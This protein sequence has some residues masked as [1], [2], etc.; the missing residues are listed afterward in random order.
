MELTTSTRAVDS[1]LTR[2]LGVRLHRCIVD[3]VTCQLLHCTDIFMH[4]ADMMGCRDKTPANVTTRK[5]TNGQWLH[6]WIISDRTPTHAPWTGNFTSPADLTAR[7]AWILQNTTRRRLIDG[8][9]CLR[10]WVVDQEYH[11]WSIKDSFTLSVGMIFKSS[12]NKLTNFSRWIQRNFKNEYRRTIRA[13]PECMDEHK[14][15]VQSSK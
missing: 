13:K 2:R 12:C 3:D 15:Y 5:K 9:C 4:S 1:T 6:Q 7:S 14:A 8:P 11:A 10:C